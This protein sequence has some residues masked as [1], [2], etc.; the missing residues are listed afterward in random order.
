MLIGA[1]VFDTRANA[2]GAVGSALAV[3]SIAMYTLLSLK[4]PT[5]DRVVDCEPLTEG[6]AKMQLLTRLEAR[7]TPNIN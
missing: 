1:V 6:D 5:K 3:G 2:K 7:A 4:D